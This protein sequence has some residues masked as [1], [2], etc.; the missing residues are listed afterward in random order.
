ME[1][2]G[3]GKEG[4]QHVWTPL[5]K[6]GSGGT[7]RDELWAGKGSVLLEPRFDLAPSARSFVLSLVV[8]VRDSTHSSLTSESQ[9]PATAPAQGGYSANVSLAVTE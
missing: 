7:G 4:S 5:E 8:Q 9:V 2:P 3:E 1:W 6:S